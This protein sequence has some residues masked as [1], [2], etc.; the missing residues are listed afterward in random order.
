[1]INCDQE[2]LDPNDEYEYSD[3]NSVVTM[4]QQKLAFL[5]IEEINK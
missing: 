2:L 5:I 1:M 3:D 4:K